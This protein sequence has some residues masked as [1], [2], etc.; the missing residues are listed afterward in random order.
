M[1]RDAQGNPITIFMH[2][3]LFEEESG[4]FI[5]Q[6]NQMGWH[7]S[8]HLLDTYLLGFMYR[9]IQVGWASHS[10]YFIFFSFLLFFLTYFPFYSILI[11]IQE[12]KI[13]TVSPEV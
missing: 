12:K 5:V 11:I 4:L 7:L 8:P 10:L 3:C 9:R 13:Y 6:L 2:A 1:R